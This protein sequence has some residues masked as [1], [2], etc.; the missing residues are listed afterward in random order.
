MPKFNCPDNI[1]QIF[2]RML[3]INSNDKIEGFVKKHINCKIYSYHQINIFI[4][5]FISKYNKFKSKLT[6]L[7]EG[8]DVTEKCIEEFAK[9]TQYFTNGGFAQLLTT[10]DNNN[11]EKDYIDKL[12][13]IYNNDLNNMEFED[14]L[15]FITIKK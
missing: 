8:K 6:F 5:L 1:I 2:N 10:I 7:N 15:I 11:E 3:E 14:P 4:Q 13:E 9:C 12:S